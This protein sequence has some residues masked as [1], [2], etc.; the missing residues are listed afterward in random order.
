MSF[1]NTWTILAAIWVI[2]IPL[3]QQIYE[4]YMEVSKNAKVESTSSSP[5]INITSLSNKLEQLDSLS[6]TPPPP[7][8]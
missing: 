7:W 8:Q 3:G 6:E 5:I 1:C 4:V 2:L